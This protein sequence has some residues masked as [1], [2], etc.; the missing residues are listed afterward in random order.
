LSAPKQFNFNGD[1]S[2]GTYGIYY[3]CVCTERETNKHSW[4][5]F[6]MPTYSAF[7]QHDQRFG[8]Q[9]AG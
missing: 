4:L 5:L 9:L 1:C 8:L 2:L 7:N 6:K 3:M